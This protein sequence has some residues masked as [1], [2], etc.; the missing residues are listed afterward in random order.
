MTIRRGI[1]A[2]AVAATTAAGML[3]TTGPAGATPSCGSISKSTVGSTLKVTVGAPTTLHG[4]NHYYGFAETTQTCKYVGSATTVFVI[5]GTP[6]TSANFAKLQAY[7]GG[8]SVPGVGV[9]AF[10][11]IAYSANHV[12]DLGIYALVPGKAI[13]SVSAS[14]VTAAS[15]VAFLRHLATKL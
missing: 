4:T 9:K 13:V 2:L 10:K 8:V 7:L 5:F 14:K 12:A 11:T 15:E 1:T 3:T 6:A